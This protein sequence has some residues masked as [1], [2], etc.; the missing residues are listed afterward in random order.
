MFFT[1]ACCLLGY[2]RSSTN[3]NVIKHEK[4]NGSMIIL[5]N[6]NF[7][8]KIK[9]KYKFALNLNKLVTKKGQINAKVK[10]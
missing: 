8:R 7:T 9:C 1:S 6:I 3:I 5:F 2:K 10:L 4:F